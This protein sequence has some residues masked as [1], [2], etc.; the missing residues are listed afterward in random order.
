[1]DTAC[2]SV[3]SL[4]ASRISMTLGSSESCPRRKLS[5][6]HLYQH[7][8]LGSRAENLSNARLTSTNFRQRAM[9]NELSNQR[10]RYMH[11]LSPKACTSAG[12]QMSDPVSTPARN[13]IA[14]SISF[15]PWQK[16]FQ[17]LKHAR[18]LQTFRIL[19]DCHLGVLPYSLC[20]HIS[21][22]P[23]TPLAS[24]MHV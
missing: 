3:A 7:C 13:M 21:P 2:F 24:S 17:V 11:F 18:C 5:P 16:H 9:C 19:I 8:Q 14:C 10:A 20:R 22:L 1:M 23:S 4:Q 12:G 15:L 6:Q